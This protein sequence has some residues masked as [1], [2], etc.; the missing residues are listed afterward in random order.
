MGTNGQVTGEFIVK[1]LMGE[2]SL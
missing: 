1:T 2:K